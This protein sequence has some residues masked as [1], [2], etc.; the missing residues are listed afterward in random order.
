MALSSP[1]AK[2]KLW[3]RGFVLGTFANFVSSCNYFMIMVVMTEYAMAVYEAPAAAAGLTASIF[4]F[5]TLIA[6]LVGSL[7]IGRA[8]KKVLLFTAAIAEIAFTLLYLLNLSLAGLLAVRFLHGFFFGIFSTTMAT[9]ITEIVPTSRKGEGIG[10]Y[11]L[12][13]TLGA[14]IGPF[15]GI[16]ISRYVGYND[17][18][19]WAAIVVVLS[20]PLLA[21]LKLPKHTELEAAVIE[22]V[23]AEVVG[24]ETETAREDSAARVMEKAGHAHGQD[25]PKRRDRTRIIEKSTLPIG[26]VCCLIFFGYSSLLTFLT[27]FANEVGLTRAASVYFIAYAISMFITRP[28]SGRAFD[29]RGARFVMV[30]AFF[31]FMAG[32]LVLAFASNDWMILGSALLCGYGVGTLQSC[33][34]AMAV[35]RAPVKRLP[36]TNATFYMMIDAGAGAGPIL[37]GAI[38]PII[39]YSMMYVAMAGVGLI[40]LLLFFAVNKRYG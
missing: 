16:L 33:G 4:I 21:L 29:R 7:V 10:Y 40:A 22:E 36:A 18:F 9:Y 32:M 2:D 38:T 25:E 30:P 26:F 27:P 34:L 3:T 37:L 15:A 5:G 35:K 17:L 23:S 24:S 39:G 8:N 20:V 19:F 14:A 13:V 28:L 31:S 1:N 11:M 12:S 6:R